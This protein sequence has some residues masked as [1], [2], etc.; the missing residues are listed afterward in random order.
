M[1][2]YFRSIIGHEAH[3]DARR[4]GR[5]AVQVYACVRGSSTA[6][7]VFAGFR[8]DL[9]VELVGVEAGGQGIDSGMHAACLAG[10]KGR[11]GV[12]QGYKSV[13]LQNE[14]GLMQDT[15]SVS[16]GLDDIGIGPILADL[17]QRRPT[18]RSLGAVSHDAQRGD[19][20]GARERSCVGQ[21][22]KL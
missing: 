13:F 18:R 22:A 6:S 19:H 10:G 16:A 8:D 14:E 2:T 21:L 11:P 12:A 17:H 1:V 9:S 7:G 3:A 15:Q 20:P 4:G 5:V